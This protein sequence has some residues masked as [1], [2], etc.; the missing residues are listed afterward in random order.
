MPVQSTRLRSTDSL[1]TPMPSKENSVGQTFVEIPAGSFQMGLSADRVVGSQCDAE[2]PQ[3]EVAIT[4]PFLLCQH[5]VTVGQFRMFVDATGYQTEAER[6]G[7]GCNGLNLANGSVEQRADWTWRSP[8]FPQTDQ[9]PVVGL[10]WDDANAF[11]K[12]LSTRESSVYR[13]PTEAEWEYACRAGTQTLFNTG[14]TSDS[15]IGYANFAEQAL[16]REFGG[17]SGASDHDDSYAFTAPVGSFLPN[18]FGLYDM[19]GNVGEWCS[20]WF[21]PHYYSASAQADPAGPN[22]SEYW[23]AVRGGSWYNTASSLRS[24]GRHDG[25]PTAASTTNGF[26]VVKEVTS[27]DKSL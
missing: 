21:D 2:R 15:L 22:R 6:T 27:P 12:W 16:L 19:H 4:T 3:H 10:S 18:S 20:D 23:R 13:L 24:S 9:H 25:V 26:R 17:A 5:E 7:S 8:G 11:C 1:T 14:D